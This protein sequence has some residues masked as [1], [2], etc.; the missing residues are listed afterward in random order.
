MTRKKEVVKIWDPGLRRPRDVLEVYMRHGV[1]NALLSLKQP[2]GMSV[3]MATRLFVARC[4][5]EVE[6]LVPRTTIERGPTAKAIA[7]ADKYARGQVSERGLTSAREAVRMLTTLIGHSAK[8]RPEK[9]LARAAWYAAHDPKKRKAERYEYMIKCLDSLVES[10]SGATES[11]VTIIQKEFN[12]LAVMNGE[13]GRLIRLETKRANLIK[14]RQICEGAIDPTIVELPPSGAYGIGVALERQAAA[15][16][17]D[18][19]AKEKRKLDESLKFLDAM[20]LSQEGNG[21]VC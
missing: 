17:V 8:S 4:A 5:Y 13:Y 2:H 15:N 6:Y 14:R 16:S 11:V 21:N 3:E 18:V 20:F 12:E 1:K 9:C 19:I 10:R 7:A